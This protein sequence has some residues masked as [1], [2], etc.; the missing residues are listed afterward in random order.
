MKKALKTTLI[1]YIPA[2]FFCVLLDV[3]LFRGFFL[4]EFIS[5]DEYGK[6]TEP[7]TNL[8]Y[9]IRKKGDEFTLKFENESLVP[10]YF[11]TYRW[12]ELMQ[13]VP[14]SVFF[15]Y[16]GRMQ[17][18]YP[19]LSTE[20]NYGFDCGSGV[21]MTAIRPR[22]SFEIT[23]SYSELVESYYYIYDH[24]NQLERTDSI[25]KDLFHQKPLVTLVDNKFKLLENKFVRKSDS[26]EV[27]FYLPI[28]SPVKGHISYIVSNPIKFSY[29]DV[30][31]QMKKNQKERER[32]Y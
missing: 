8:H 14:D 30:I 20:L 31:E 6:M 9:E 1:L 2:V 24:F 27:K 25:A 16:A 19:H 5:D 15:A 26:I 28:F 7:P 21:G 13:K 12:N 23:K 29:F 18:T 4:S 3:F 10:H 32:Y 22:E 11:W 17:F